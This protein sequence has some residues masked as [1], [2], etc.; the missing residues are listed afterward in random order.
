MSTPE[1]FRR[2]QCPPHCAVIGRSSEGVK[3]SEFL[4]YIVK[5][6]KFFYGN[7]KGQV[8]KF[9]FIYRQ[10]CRRNRDL[11]IDTTPGPSLAIRV[12]RQYL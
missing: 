7:L 11:S 5:P 10:K 4:S 3:P 9:S 8:P 6:L 12:I 1:M 2:S